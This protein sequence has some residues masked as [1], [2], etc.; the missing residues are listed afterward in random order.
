MNYIN[1]IFLKFIIIAES[2]T[3]ISIKISKILRIGIKKLLLF[4]QKVLKNAF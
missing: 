3:G 1:K 2:I 4:I